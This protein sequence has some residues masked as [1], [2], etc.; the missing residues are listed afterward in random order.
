MILDS[1]DH[2]IL[3]AL[4]MNSR[5]SIRQIAK[6]TKLRPSTVHDRIQ[7][8]KEG[9][10]IEKFTLKL[11]NKAV[12][13]NFIV[14]MLVAGKPTE[15]L[16]KNSIDQQHTKEV[17]GVTGEYDLLLKLKFK[18][19]TEFNDYIIRFRKENKDVTKTLTMVVTV[20]LKE[21]M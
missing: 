8:L 17:F 12:G 2:T 15:Y 3:N 7:K 5:Q 4:R 14:F 13:E 10:V 21:E 19:V 20:A 6:A 16:G 11:N 1:S 9:S 18:D